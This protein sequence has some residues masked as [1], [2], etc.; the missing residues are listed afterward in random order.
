MEV[1]IFC[2]K[3]YH[4]DRV[5]GGCQGVAMQLLLQVIVLLT[6]YEVFFKWLLLIFLA[7]CYAVLIGFAHLEQVK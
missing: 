6:C 1:L 7:G 3:L 5:L 4:I 2:Q